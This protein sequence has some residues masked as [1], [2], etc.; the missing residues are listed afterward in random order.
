VEVPTAEA[1]RLVADGLHLGG[2]GELRHGGD[3][4]RRRMR[5]LYGEDA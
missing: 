4:E 1:V 5:A 2:V 3:E